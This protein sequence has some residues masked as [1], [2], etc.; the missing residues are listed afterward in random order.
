[1]LLLVKILGM[2]VMRVEGLMLMM[3]L[4]NFI[5]GILCRKLVLVFWL[6]VRMM[7]LVL[8]FL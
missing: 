6:M 2:L 8:S 5:L 7:V 1:M 3:L 4:W